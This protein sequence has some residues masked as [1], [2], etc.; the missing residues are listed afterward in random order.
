MEKRTENKGTINAKKID[1]AFMPVLNL[2]KLG[3][4]IWFLLIFMERN[5][6]LTQLDF[7]QWPLLILL[8]CL[9]TIVLIKK[10]AILND[11]FFVWMLT[12]CILV[13]ISSLWADNIERVFRDGLY[14]LKSVV[15]VGY[16]MYIAK[17]EENLDFIFNA[18]IISTCINIISIIPSII[19]QGSSQIIART[20]ITLGGV[21]F[22]VNQICPDIVFATLILVY[23]VFLNDISAI[24]R[25]VYIILS[26]AFI[27]VI[28]LLGSRGS[29]AVVVIGIILNGFSGALGNK[30]KNVLVGLFFVVGIFYVFM[31]VPIFYDAIGNRIEDFYN[32]VSGVY[33]VSANQSSDLSRLQL[34]KDGFK[35][36][37]DNPVLGYGSGNYASMHLL[38]YGSII[39]AHNNYIELLVNLGLL[40]IIMYY[41]IYFKIWHYSFFAKSNIKQIEFAKELIFCMFLM[42]MTLVTY[43]IMNMHLNLLIAYALTKIV[44]KTS[45]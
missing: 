1:K 15:V 41:W 20:Q 3:K 16:A 45:Y 21:L 12:F 9:F 39:Y 19:E 42:D 38:N 10:N 13:F 35:M 18:I 31:N 44:V 11:N 25:K 23:K 27:L 28:S 2:D 7:V 5:A 22:N 37:L 17:K 24:R 30:I 29:L 34:I 4:I 33:S 36:F 8:A 26:F 14:L 43:N 6:Y 40:G 32:L